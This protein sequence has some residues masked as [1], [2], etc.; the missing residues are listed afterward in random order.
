MTI[1]LTTTTVALGLLSV[2]VLSLA[3][4][5][6]GSTLSASKGDTRYRLEPPAVIH[7]DAGQPQRTLPLAPAGMAEI[8]ER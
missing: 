1:E 2:T 4:M 6:T 3:A 8:E 7:N 5:L